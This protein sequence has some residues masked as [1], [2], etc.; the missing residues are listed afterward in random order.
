VTNTGDE[1]RVTIKGDGI[2][3]KVAKAVFEVKKDLV[4][5]IS[6]PLSRHPHLV[7]V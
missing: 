4:T 6:S 7:T 5:R 2:F 3:L 1:V